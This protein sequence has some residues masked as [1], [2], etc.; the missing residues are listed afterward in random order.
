VANTKRSW[1]PI[2]AGVAVLFV[3]LGIGAAV[4]GVA[5]FRENVHMERGSSESAAAEAFT[6]A[7]RA[8][9]DPRPVL[10][11]DDSRRAHLTA[12][13]ESRKNPGTV[14]VVQVL[15][16]DPKERA[17]A[18]VALPMWLLRL[19]SGPIQFGEYASGIGADGLRLT[20]EDI[21]RYG[22]GVLFEVTRGSGARVLVS[23]Q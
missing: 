18:R 14:S 2:V 1:W 5:L 17:L 12:G 9:P 19:K 15:A 4:V 13:I 10:E 11:F 8:F 6:T 3:F 20:T 7:L 22:P 23:A 21:E 16:W